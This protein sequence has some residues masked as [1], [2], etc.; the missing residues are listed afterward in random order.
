[1]EQPILKVQ[2]TTIISPGYLAEL[3]AQACN[4]NTCARHWADPIDAQLKK[5]HNRFESNFSHK[6]R[7]LQAAT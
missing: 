3:L 7:R 2:N 5:A 1:M 6:G 4:R